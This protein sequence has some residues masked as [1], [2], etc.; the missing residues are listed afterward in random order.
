MEECLLY[1][2]VGVLFVLVFFAVRILSTPF[3]LVLFAA[4]HH[5]WDMWAALGAMRPYCHL[6]L[7]AEFSLQVS[8]ANQRRQRVCVC[9]DTDSV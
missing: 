7:A 4:Q 3:C 1:R 8:T 5:G 9:V 2:V 6:A